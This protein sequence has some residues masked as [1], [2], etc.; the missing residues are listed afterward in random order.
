MK[1][2]ETDMKKDNPNHQRHSEA[3]HGQ[4]GSSSSR[5]LARG[6]PPDRGKAVLRPQRPMRRLY[7]DRQWQSGPL[8]SHEG[9]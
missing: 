8:L 3:D 2:K 5:S 1:K 7:G 4:P 9:G 6:S